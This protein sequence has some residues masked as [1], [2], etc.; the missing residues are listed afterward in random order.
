NDTLDA[1]IGPLN[2][3]AD[4]LD[5][6][7]KGEIPAP[8]AQSY[9]GD[10][11]TIKSNLNTC[12]AA[13]GALVADAGT[14]AEAARAGRF[15]T[16]ADVSRHNGD[17]RA[18][19]DGVNATLDV[20]VDKVFWY[21]A[22]LDAVPFPVSVTDSGLR[23]TFVNKAAE[24]KLG[25]RRA[26]LAGQP[27]RKWGST[28]CG[29][30]ACGIERLKRGIPRAEFTFG[31]RSFQIDSSELRD[32]RGA[33]IGFV[34]VVQDVTARENV[35]A[36]ERFE[37]E[38]L[39]ANL[40][41]L[42]QGDLR[43]DL[44][45]AAGD[46]LTREARENFCRAAESLGKVRDALQALVREADGVARGIMHGRLD[47]RADAAKVSG[48][49]RRVL[50]E[51]NRALGSIVGNL[52]A[53]PTPIQFMDRDFRIQYINEAGAR[54]LGK[55]KK[56]L[57]GTGLTCADQWNT[58]KCRTADCP[59]AEAMCSDAA[60]AC[61][62]D[63]TIGGRKLD[64]ACV[65]APLRD[66]K[67]EIVG[68]FEFVTDQSDAKAA[69]R[70]AEKIVAYQNSEAERLAAGM[71]TMAAHGDFSVRVDFA[72]ADDDTA[73]S[74]AALERIRGAYRK[75]REAVETMGRDVENLAKAAV[76]GRLATRADAEIH[77]GEFREI[78]ADFNATL[79]ALLAPVDEARAVLERVAQRDLTARVAC[80]YQGDHAK[81]KDALN[82]AVS[83]L[84]EGLQSV[85]AAAS[86]VTAASGQ[87]STSSQALAQAASEQASSLEEIS[88]SLQEMSSM[89]RQNSDNA[90]KA[91]TMSDS[92][93]GAAAKGKERM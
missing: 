82:T 32:R 3:A 41:L 42:A 6:I 46:E 22:I 52:E 43:I 59:C 69:V 65:S 70:R 33:G 7:A 64:I 49:Y 14:L 21:E 92:T 31:D 51:F 13:V 44:D 75:F 47:D 4:Y 84:D 76:E 20:V 86:Q 10:F 35:A 23:W 36:F 29:T 15:E 74:K 54:L 81:L 80:Q 88:S 53:I 39:V 18:I 25:R 55:S 26:E 48:E 79:D 71:E 5:K 19:V 45:V 89:T 50:D 90:Q 24:E 72:A 27:C 67:G 40:E 28:I 77:R 1:V 34:E 85:A 17:F 91:R 9:N 11:N 93:L 78:V 37:T 68:S 16:R 58:S 38:R 56:Q 83:H 66:A 8:I 12:V 57:Q 63:T 60:F 61:E 2:V 87:I 62:N 30:E 73:P